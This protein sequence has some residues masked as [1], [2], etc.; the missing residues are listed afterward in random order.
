MLVIVGIVVG[1]VEIKVAQSA[2]V[3]E[4]GGLPRARR[5]HQLADGD[6]LLEAAAQRI[7]KALV[8]RDRTLS[9]NKPTRVHSV[10]GRPR[11]MVFVS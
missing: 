11:V 5:L 9:M 8:S 1:F 10:I 2:P 4:E 7:G 6:L 3:L